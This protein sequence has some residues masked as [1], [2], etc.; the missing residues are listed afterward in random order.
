MVKAWGSTNGEPPWPVVGVTSTLAGSGHGRGWML[1]VVLV[2][3]MVLDERVMRLG[4]QAPRRL[5]AQTV[6]GRGGRRARVLGEGCPVGLVGPG[7]CP[8]GLWAG[9]VATSSAW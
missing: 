8:V 3:A 6:V 1:L 5:A 7:G 4:R 2:V 9:G